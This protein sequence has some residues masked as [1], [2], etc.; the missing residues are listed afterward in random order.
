MLNSNYDLIKL[1][2]SILA[3]V[4]LH[5]CKTADT[6]GPE[7]SYLEPIV[8]PHLSTINL[9]VEIPL[10]EV[11]KQINAE[12]K[13]LL[14][15][16]SSMEDNDFVIKIW[17]RNN[18]IIQAEG[19]LFKIMVPLRVW[20]KA[21]LDL[22]GFGLN[23]AETK[24]TEF[25][26]DLNFISKI[27]IDENWDILTQTTG[28]GFEW[29]KKPVI[30]IGFFEISLAS[31]AEGMIKGQQEKISLMLDSQVSG[32]LKIKE[33]IQK[34]WNKIQEPLL[35]SEEYNA[36]LKVTPEN[37]TATNFQGDGNMARA[38]LGISAATHVGKR[39]EESDEIPLP[40]L[41]TVNQINDKFSIGM[42]AEISQDQASKLL[43]ENLVN[44]IF[45]S[46]NGKRTV[47]ITSA[48]LYGS[49]ESI[50]I[51]AGLAGDVDGTV[52]LS[53]IPYYNETDQTLG[54]K[55]LDYDLNTKNRLVKTA[56]WFAKTRFIS[57]MEEAFKIPLGKEIAEAKQAIQENLDQKQIAE[58]VTLDGSLSG[59]SPSEVYITPTSIVAVVVATGHARIKIE[60]L[61]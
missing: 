34:A 59:L 47:T 12:L 42:I 22:G 55:N 28:N 5:G 17:K 16:D 39:P 23:I 32:Q 20:T 30:K 45:T 40:P 4:W 53:G 15:E 51:K 36:W 29:V 18:I 19:E 11:Q 38:I 26:L 41:Q 49:G 3:I 7:E 6:S 33:H 9:P 43:Q 10:Q 35:L 58:G 57:E 50:V 54:I 2:L 60:E 61:K 8:K 24:E 31:F 56:N 37:T 14:Y 52:Y 48:D 1:I 13:G 25:E 46:D 21:G 27:S 44:K